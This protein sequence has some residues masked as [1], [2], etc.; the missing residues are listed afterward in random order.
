[1][2]STISYIFSINTAAIINSNPHFHHSQCF[3]LHDLYKI[4]K[5]AALILYFIRK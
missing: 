5:T 3:R 1:M 2:N 4:Y